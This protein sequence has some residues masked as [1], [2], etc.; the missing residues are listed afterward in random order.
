MPNLDILRNVFY[1]PQQTPGLSPLYSDFV[2]RDFLQIHEIVN[3]QKVNNPIPILTPD[4]LREWRKTRDETK[5][6]RFR[7]SISPRLAL[8]FTAASLIFLGVLTQALGQP[9]ANA[10][11]YHTPHPSR[12]ENVAKKDST[13]PPFTINFI[14]DG[15]NH[16]WTFRNDDPTSGWGID[17]VTIDGVY[18]DS[19]GPNKNPLWYPEMNQGDGIS[20]L[21]SGHIANPAKGKGTMMTVV[22]NK[23]SSYFHLKGG[24]LILDLA[25]PADLTKRLHITN[26]GLPDL[27]YGDALS[28]YILGTD[29]LGD[30]EDAVI[31]GA[32][33]AALNG[34]Y[35][36]RFDSN[37]NPTGNWIF[38]GSDVFRLYL[39]TVFKNTVR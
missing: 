21:I 5:R 10:E 38:L 3:Q 29:A 32:V 24:E 11:G 1:L 39:P 25:K 13:L 7:L 33:N 2:P 28:A 9:Q 36:L 17:D 34:R 19:F 37:F 12:I 31:K 22:T 27:I 20:V 23:D 16:N 6:G 30:Y 26:T 18:T 15:K 8:S 14:Y 4:F 35:R